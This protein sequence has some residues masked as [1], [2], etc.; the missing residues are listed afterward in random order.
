MAL[1][2]TP[3][4]VFL[5]VVAEVLVVTLLGGLVGLAIGTGLTGVVGR[6]MGL[7]AAVTPA[8]VTIALSTAGGVGLIAGLFPALR[9][10]R[11]SPVEALR[12]G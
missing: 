2:A 11:I 5:H 12:Y 1:G 10:A 7:P 6:V 8:I 9:A 3:G 4:G